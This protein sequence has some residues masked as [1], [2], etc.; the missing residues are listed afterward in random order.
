MYSSSSMRA[1]RA[2][3]PARTPTSAFTSYIRPLSSIQRQPA[4]TT[5]ARPLPA[6]RGFHSSTVWA[7]KKQAPTSK[8]EARNP[9]DISEL[10]VL[11]ATPV[12]STNIEATLPG[13]FLLNSGLSILGGDGALLVG[14]E[15]F[16]W[17]PWAARADSDTSDKSKKLQLYNERGQLD[18]PAEA[19][20]VLGLVWPRPG[21]FLRFLPQSS[22]D[23]KRIQ[24][25]TADGRGYRFLQIYL[26]LAQ[27][28][29]F[30]L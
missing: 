5:L 13:G 27:V 28:R 21:G 26:S 23:G 20:S 19:F 17:R 7:R 15:A 14:G 2:L 10:D 4:C 18:L 29:R 6:Q 24:G 3:R 11:G 22:P 12:P 30:A 9:A 25:Q 8:S 16:A 1:L